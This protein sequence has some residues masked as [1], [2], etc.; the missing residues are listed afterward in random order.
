[1]I[2]NVEFFDENPLE[3][4]ATSLSYKVDKTMFF[5]YREVMKPRQKTI[6]RFLTDVCGVGQV[7]FYPVIRSDLPSILDTITRYVKQEIEAGNRV[8]FDLT[9]GDSLLHVAFGILSREFMAPMYLNEIERG[10]IREYGYRDVILLSE[11]AEKR[12]V[13]VTIDEFIALYGGVINYRHKKNFKEFSEERERD[14]ENLWNLSKK[15]EDKWVHYSAVLRKYAPDKNWKV[16]VD[17]TKFKSD[18]SRMRS[19]GNIRGFHQFLTDASKAGLLYVYSKGR[20]GY[21]FRY[22]DKMIKELFWDSG[23]ILEMYTFL[24]AGRNEA[25]TDCRVGVHI[26]W[27][28]VIEPAGGR[29]V[30]N[31]ID[32]M[33]MENNLPTFVSCKIGKVDQMA[34]YELET[35]A[36]RFGGRYARKA[37][38]VA[39]PLS[40]GHMRRAEE[41]GIEVRVIK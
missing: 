16:F 20:K 19:A 24:L 12:K 7:E 27:D 21:H 33:S 30:L 36:N 29:D 26:D 37:L 38:A 35:I 1:M 3:N 6:E 25:N 2:V 14:I 15:Y 11:V 22:K 8:F 41:M 28:G 23:S 9:G 10:E 18:F 5:G 40:P 34:L 4:V 31:E 13:H 32:V 17:G 39:Q